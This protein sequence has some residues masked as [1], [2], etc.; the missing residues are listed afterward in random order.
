MVYTDIVMDMEQQHNKKIEKIKQILKNYLRIQVRKYILEIVKLIMVLQKDLRILKI[1]I[2]S[3]ILTQ[4]KQ[5]PTE[6]NLEYY[7]A[8]GGS[9]EFNKLL[10]KYNLMFEWETNCIAC[11]Y[12]DDDDDDDMT[13]MIIK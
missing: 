1:N 10:V 4:K 11:L 12:F 2:L 9:K 13:M 7:T 3:H 5:Q 8:Y 6:P